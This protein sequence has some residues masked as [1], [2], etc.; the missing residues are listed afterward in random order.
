MD[1]VKAYRLNSASSPAVYNGVPGSRPASHATMGLIKRLT[2]AS[3][4]SVAGGSAGWALY[5]R[6]TRFVPFDTTSAGY[7]T[8]IASQINPSN[9]PPACV[10]HAIRVVP[11]SRLKTTDQE[12]LTKEFCRGVWSGWGFWYQRRFLER[13]WRPLEGRE[14]MLWTQQEMEKSAYEQGTM[15]SDHFEVV[16]RSPEKVR[17]A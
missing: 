10:D 3:I 8:S 16:E 2:Q 1:V 12:T 11:L 9:N 17:I 13:K 5:T 14:G 7:P 15:I 6:N 4:A